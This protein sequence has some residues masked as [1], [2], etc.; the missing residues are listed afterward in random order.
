MNAKNFWMLAMLACCS[1]AT[2]LRAQDWGRDRERREHR[3]RRHTASVRESHGREGRENR[4]VHRDVARAPLA[5]HAGILRNDAFLRSVRGRERAERV[6]GRYYW[7]TDRGIRYVHFYDPHG[8]HWYG[9]YHGRDFYWTRWWGNRWWWYDGPAHRWVYWWGGYWWWAGPGGVAYVYVNNDFVPYHP[10]AVAAPVA[11]RP[12]RDTFSSDGTRFVQIMGPRSEAF[13]YDRSNGSNVYLGYLGPN[14][15]SVRFAG[16]GNT[17]KPLQILANFKDGTFG[18]YDAN[19]KNLQGG[20]ATPAGAPTQPP[21]AAPTA[22]ATTGTPA[23]GMPTSA[24]PPLEGAPP[25]A[26]D[27]PPGAPPADSGAASPDGSDQPPTTT[28]H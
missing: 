26:D 17:G 7:H 11:A 20:P 15:E 25:S 3:E 10:A 1:A 22:A 23:A 6:A 24:P 12:G 4:E 13:L 8:Y 16:G 5:Y 28:P 21:V 27:Q 9:F 19:G 18:V 2:G 14:V